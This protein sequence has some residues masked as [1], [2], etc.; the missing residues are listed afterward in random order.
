MIERNLAPALLEAASGFPVVTLT[1]PRQSGKTTLCRHLFDDR[2]Y[3][4][5]EAPDLRAQATTDP[6]GFLQG[7]VGGA[8][9]DEVQRAPQLLSYLQVEV[10]RMPTPGRFILTGSQNLLLLEAI[11]QSLAGRTAVVHLLPCSFDEL[12]RFKQP[13]SD[14]FA[15]L[16]TGGYP[17]PHDR[18]A[19]ADR[20]LSAYVSTYVE[21]DVRQVLNV[22]DLST[23]RTFLQL[24]AGRTSQLL[25][26][27]GLAS[28]AG[29][30]QA[31][32]RA[33]MSVLEASFVAHRLVPM[34]PNHRKRLVRTP[35]LHLLDTGVACHLLGIRTPEELR[36]HP[37]RGPIFETWVF[38]ELL[39][40]R[41]HQGLP[42]DLHFYRD[43]HGREADIV[44]GVGSVRFCVEAKSGATVAGDGIRSAL[45]AAEHVRTAGGPAVRD[46]RPVIVYGGERRSVTQG[47]TLLPWCEIHQFDWAPG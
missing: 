30:S 14:L 33:W 47:V 41:L 15:T 11:S 46:V 42:A 6:R 32:A 21:R 37:L 4:S 22:G 1:G 3:L 12:G 45:R 7:V 28:D 27:S 9:I 19:P 18:N 29:V 43:R 2:P 38:T 17:A 36:L 31:T 40:H 35:K 39:K 25:N 13:A 10:D 24:A 20:W 23:F 44:V 34:L 8:V 16:W 5:L 26:L